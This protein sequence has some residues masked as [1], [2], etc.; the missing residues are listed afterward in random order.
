MLDPTYKLV[1]PIP[2]FES[3][4][5]EWQEY[6]NGR[7]AVTPIRKNKLRICHRIEHKKWLVVKDHSNFFLPKLHLVLLSLFLSQAA[8]LRLNL[9]SLSVYWQQTR[10]RLAGSPVHLSRVRQGLNPGPLAS[11]QPTRL[12]RI[13][14]IYSSSVK[15]HC[16]STQTFWDAGLKI[17]E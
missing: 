15:Y 1:W 4:P 2:G 16:L 10:F 12:W 13:Y 8:Q 11:A 14:W 7:H 6:K 3:V 17:W 9:I 5:T